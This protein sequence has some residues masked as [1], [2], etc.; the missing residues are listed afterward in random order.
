MFHRAVLFALLFCFVP[1][2]VLG[3]ERAASTLSPQLLI[4]GKPAPSPEYAYYYNK[5]LQWRLISIATGFVG[6]T[7][8][9]TGVV[10][11]NR[12]NN[13]K[14]NA[15]GDALINIGFG[16]DLAALLPLGV[17]YYWG[18]KLR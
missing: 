4:F 13:A 17:A 2:V 10:L 1:E 11:F 16:V 8:L 15:A 3:Q 5:R 14:K 6:T 12:G 7:T 18:R 9:F